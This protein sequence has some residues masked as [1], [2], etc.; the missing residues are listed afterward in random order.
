MDAS[1]EK[2]LDK[3]FILFLKASNILDTPMIQYLKKSNP[4]NEIIPEY[5]K[6]KGGTLIRKDYYG[7][8]FQIGCRYKF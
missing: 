2:K 5:E 7:Q 3:G 4:S 1:L 6:Y 8:N